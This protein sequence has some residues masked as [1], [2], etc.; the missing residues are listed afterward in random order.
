MTISLFDYCD[1]HEVMR[2]L[3]TDPCRTSANPD[4][5]AIPSEIPNDCDMTTEFV[6]NEIESDHR[7]Y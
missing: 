1:I 7:K 6:P 2:D 3:E 5:K 4:T